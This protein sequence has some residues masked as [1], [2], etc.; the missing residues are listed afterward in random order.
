MAHILDLKSK[1]LNV[2]TSGPAA[3]NKTVQKHLFFID[4]LNTASNTQGNVQCLTL[5]S[6]KTAEKNIRISFLYL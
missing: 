4:D 5:L 6:A 2:I 1:A 3:S